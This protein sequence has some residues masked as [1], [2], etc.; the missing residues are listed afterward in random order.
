MPKQIKSTKQQAATVQ[1]KDLVN[2]T[3]LAKSIVTSLKK[4]QTAVIKPGDAT[5][6]AF[7]AAEQIAN[8]ELTRRQAVR[9]PRKDKGEYA[10]T[11]GAAKRRQYLRTGSTTGWQENIDQ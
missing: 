1:D 3:K 10:A 7:A 4:N 5:I 8:Y 9:K 11:E 6:A 2:F